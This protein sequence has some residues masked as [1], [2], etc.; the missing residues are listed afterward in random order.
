MKKR[1]WYFLIPPS[2]PASGSRSCCKMQS[3]G[4]CM[5]SFE[6]YSMNLGYFVQQTSPMKKCYWHI[7][8]SASGPASGSRRCCKMQTWGPCNLASS[9]ESYNMNL[10]FFVQHTTSPVKK[11]CRYFL[12][13]P[14][15]PASG[16]RS[17]C[18]MESWGRS[19]H[20]F[21]ALN[22]NFWAHKMKIYTKIYWKWSWLNFG[23]M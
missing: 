20:S 3:W 14:S 9:F 16:S 13:S 4:P 12:I 23:L 11:I 6:A 21:E 5:Y 15:G 22:V 18:Y 1:Y 17:C 10:G 8:I 19:I 2:G 7:L